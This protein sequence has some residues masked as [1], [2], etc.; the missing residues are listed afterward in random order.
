MFGMA[1]AVKRDLAAS[2]QQ[3]V[4]KRLRETK[5]L[6]AKDFGKAEFDAIYFADLSANGAKEPFYVVDLPSSSPVL[7]KLVGTK[8]VIYERGYPILSNIGIEVQIRLY[9]AFKGQEFAP[10]RELG[11]R[12]RKSQAVA[13][14]DPN[15]LSPLQQAI[16]SLRTSW[17]T[18]PRVTRFTVRSWRYRW[19][20]WKLATVPDVPMIDWTGFQHPQWSD[21]DRQDQRESWHRSDLLAF[22]LCPDGID[23]GIAAHDKFLE[24]CR[25]FNITGETAKKKVIS[26]ITGIKEPKA[27]VK[28]NPNEVPHELEVYEAITN[29]GVLELTKLS[30]NSNSYNNYSKEFYRDLKRDKERSE[31]KIRNSKF[32]SSPELTPCGCDTKVIHMGKQHRVS[33]GNCGSSWIPA[34]NNIRKIASDKPDSLERP[35]EKSNKRKYYTYDG[36]YHVYTES[37]NSAY[38]WKCY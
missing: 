25:A 10:C 13:V 16:K 9:Q 3:S 37:T 5:S 18:R 23:A 24:T 19:Q 21:A 4:Y 1:E 26:E 6:G 12:S 22:W 30:K 32:K 15:Q 28:V 2:R 11:T 17:A 29:K 14:Y 38:E 8:H 35:K 36:K 7:H 34:S 20:L 33:C 31:E 27:P